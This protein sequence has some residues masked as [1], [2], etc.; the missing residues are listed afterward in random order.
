MLDLKL[1]REQPT[2]VQELLNRRDSEGYDIQ[3]ILDLDRQQREIETKRSKLSA[4]G[5]EIGK[6]VGQKI[7]TGSDPK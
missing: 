5:N 6:T 1:I 4:K 7:R 2:Q 3:P